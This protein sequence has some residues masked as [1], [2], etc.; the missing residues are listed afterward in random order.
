LNVAVYYR[1]STKGQGEDDKYGLPR[2]RA[3]VA[4]FLKAENRYE[5]VREFEDKGFS[6][7]ADEFDRPR[8]GE[9]LV[10]RGFDAIIVPS[11]DRLA[12]DRNLDGH[13][14]LVFRRRKIELISATEGNSNDPIGELTL[15]ILAQISQYER[16]LI[17]KRM[18]GGRKVKAEQGGYAHGQP[19]YGTRAIRASK[20]LHLHPAEYAVLQDI[21]AMRGAGLPWR[22]IARSLNEKQILSRTGRAWSHVTVAGAL[23]SADRADVIAESERTSA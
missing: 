19:P 10:A 20:V 7:T 6:G 14:R 15:G 23:H 18:L 2:Q 12:R 16:H 8:L 9:M 4:K 21:R 22:A 5:V 11:W 13:L 17:T 1:V 3:D